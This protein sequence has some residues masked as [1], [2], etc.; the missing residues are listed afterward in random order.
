MPDPSAIAHPPAV[1]LAELSSN[2]AASL[3]ELTT[4]PRFGETTFDNYRPQHPSQQVVRERC[5]TF[6]AAASASSGR[7]WFWRKAR[8][9]EGLYLDGGFGVGKTHLLAASYTA[10]EG[11]KAYL[12][13][14]ELVHMIGVLGMA[15][16]TARL[17]RYRLICL[18]EFEL[19]DPGNTLIV[20][21]F[22]AKV[23]ARGT[24]VMTTSNTPPEAQGQGRFNA[25]DFKREIHSLAERFSVVPVEGPDYRRR[26]A[27]ARPLAP[28]ELAALLRAESGSSKVAGDWPQ[29]FEVLRRHHPIRY[30]ALLAGV[31]ALYLAGAA[32][33]EDQNDALRFV[34][35][36]DKL[37]DRA[38]T[39]EAA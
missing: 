33:I 10:F 27:L 3:P 37:Y 28:T 19:D 8:A 16:A 1:S 32:P 20:K 18:D 24:S 17:G 7:R 13:F 21:S 6:V 4:P 23:F 2:A 35:F 5:R 22:L 25:E 39:S 14:S 29:L 12:S 36:V 38:D 31:D 15:E 9:G 34:H 30:R 11:E 26:E